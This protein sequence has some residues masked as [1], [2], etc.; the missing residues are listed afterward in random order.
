MLLRTRSLAIVALALAL[1]GG[2]WFCWP[3][4]PGAAGTGERVRLT[5]AALAARAPPAWR[6]AAST[7]R[8][9]AAV[10]APQAPGL[11]DGGSRASHESARDLHAL[12]EQSWRS[13]DLR[14]LEEAGMALYLC[15]EHRRHADALAIAF[16]GGDPGPLHGALTPARQR[17]NAELDSRCRGFGRL[18]PATLEA[19]QASLQQ[20]LRAGGSRL[21]DGAQQE[22]SSLPT[23]LAM[24]L[25]EAGEAASFERARPT[26]IA[27]L[28]RQADYA[29]ESEG[30]QDIGIAVLLASCELGR[31]CSA[32]A[33]DALRR[34]TWQGLC[35]QGLFEGWRDG[36]APV[37]ADAV[38]QLRDRIVK[39]VQ[40]GDAAS[41]GLQ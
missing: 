20:R 4:G 40:S 17:A 21:A 23:A 29:E 2:L 26:L 22:A 7:P 39:A 16:A 32:G 13:A 9:A 18:A 37:R 34:C 14:V 41:L 12:F 6:V 5:Q 24:S 25:L 30:R 36:L 15:N 10:P 31:D 8:V 35:E 3:G 28:A 1:A 33:Y 11:T 27:A 19:M 38:Q